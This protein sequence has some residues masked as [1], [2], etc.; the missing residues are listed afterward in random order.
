[1]ILLIDP[2]DRSAM[3]FANLLKAIVIK[4]YR[5]ITQ[6]LSDKNK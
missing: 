3:L 2:V 1:M 4:H 6:S 5:I